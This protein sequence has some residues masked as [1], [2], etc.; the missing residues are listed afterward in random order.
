MPTLA[1]SAFLADNEQH[2]RRAVNLARAWFLDPNTAMWPNLEYAQTVPGLN[3][4]THGGTIEWCDHHKLLDVHDD[5]QTLLSASPNDTVA[6]AWTS[7]D[8]EKMVR[9]V[10]QLNEWIHSSNSAKKELSSSKNHGT[11]FDVNM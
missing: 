2:T 11:W 10:T 3:N 9:M 5:S 7:D 6:S 1:L 4:G 8:R